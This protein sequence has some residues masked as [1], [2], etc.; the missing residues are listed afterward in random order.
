MNKWINIEDTPPEPTEGNKVLGH[1]GKYVFECEY[2]DG[3]WCNIGGETITH[4]M[5]LPEPP[6]QQRSYPVF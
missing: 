3:C 6:E 2:E 4:W 5:P 1:N